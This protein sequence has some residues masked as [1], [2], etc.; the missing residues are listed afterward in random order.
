MQYK[1]PP[2]MTQ[3]QWDDIRATALQHRESM[4][5][6]LR[7]APARQMNMI[8]SSINLPQH[9][10]PTPFNELA[11]KEPYEPGSED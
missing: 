2:R 6:A 10:A 11:E 7:K 9:A 4:F 3:S 5:A 8:A 1:K